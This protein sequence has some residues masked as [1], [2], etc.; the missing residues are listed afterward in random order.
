VDSSTTASASAPVTL[1]PTLSPG[2]ASDDC[3]YK[4]GEKAGDCPSFCGEGEVCCRSGFSDSP[5]CS[6]LSLTAFSTI[7]HHQCVQKPVDS[8]VGDSST[9]APGVLVSTSQPGIITRTSVPAGPVHKDSNQYAQDRN[10]TDNDTNNTVIT[11]P[12]SGFG[13][14]PA[15][16]W[17]G[18]L[19]L[20]LGILAAAYL[21]TQS[22]KKGSKKPKKSKRSAREMAEANNEDSFVSNASELEM[23][24]PLVQ[25]QERGGQGDIF[26]LI[27]QNHD[28]VI[29]QAEFNQAMGL[30]AQ[31]PPVMTQRPSVAMAP[32]AMPMAMPMVMP[33]AMPAAGPPP[34]RM[35][36]PGVMPHPNMPQSN[37]VQYAQPGARPFGR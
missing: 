24:T 14:L 8:T 9:G 29:S 32:G 2:L 31:A 22:G 17:I 10:A 13:G 34:V 4:C 20:S 7:I 26:D 33:M 25:A 19:L 35:P 12:D 3:W 16:A 36:M 28:G 37:S 30:P 21:C 1:A 18:L 11:E 27:D 5:E 6:G 15:W 23:Q